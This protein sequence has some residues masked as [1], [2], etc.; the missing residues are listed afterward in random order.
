MHAGRGVAG[1]FESEIV[2]YGVRAKKQHLP[3][4]FR[5]RK[6]NAPVRALSQIVLRIDLSPT[7]KDEFE[8]VREEEESPAQS[9]QR[10]SPKVSSKLPR[11]VVRA[12]REGFTRVTKRHPFGKT[13]AIRHWL[14]A[15]RDRGTPLVFV[16]RL[17]RLIANYIPAPAI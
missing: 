9:P 3:Q 12:R 14:R 11:V 4:S 2:N 15:N 6:A 16:L 10:G 8:V 7:E 13:A 5:K 17:R 1:S